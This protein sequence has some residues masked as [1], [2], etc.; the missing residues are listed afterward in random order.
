MSPEE[1]EVMAK[2]LCHNINFQLLESNQKGSMEG[3]DC[4]YMSMTVY[5]CDCSDPENYNFRDEGKFLKVHQA[6]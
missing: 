1:L 3:N 2:S 5:D 6:F 4:S